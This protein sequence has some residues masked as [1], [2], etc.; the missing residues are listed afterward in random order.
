[1]EAKSRRAGHQRGFKNNIVTRR[2]WVD[3]R[4]RQRLG[5]RQP[6]AVFPPQDWRCKSGRE[7]GAVQNLAEF[8]GP[9]AKQGRSFLKPIYKTAGTIFSVPAVLL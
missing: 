5:V 3:W 2:A 1:M 9:L 8:F 6:S 7:L 4:A